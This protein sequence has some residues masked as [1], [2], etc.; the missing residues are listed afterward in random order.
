LII[1]RLEKRPTFLQRTKP[2]KAHRINPLEDVAIFPMQRRM[3]V[4]FDKALDF[5]KTG[6]DALLARGTAGLLFRL[7]E[8]VE[9]SGRMRRV[10]RAV[11][12]DQVRS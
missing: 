8:C 6:D 4:R 11:R 12:P 9:F 10:R 7:R 2:I 1:Q 5:L 3:T